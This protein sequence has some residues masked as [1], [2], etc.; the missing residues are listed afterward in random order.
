[1]SS[2]SKHR[3]STRRSKNR[4]ATHAGGSGNPVDRLI[5]TSHGSA[6]AVQ[7]LTCKEDFVRS[8]LSTILRE[9]PPKNVSR[10]IHWFQCQVVRANA[11]SIS[12]S[13]YTEINTYFALADTPFA[14]NIYGLFDQY[15]IY[16][17]VVNVSCSSLSSTNYLGRLTTAI[18][19]DS[20][21]NLGTESA[22][23]QYSTAQMVEVSP[24]LSV[25]RFIKPCV[26]ASVYSNS[27]AYA[28]GR[29]WIDS[30]SDTAQHYGFRS[31]W[32]GNT[33]SNLVVDLIC[34][35][36]IGARCNL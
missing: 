28:T 33:N 22:I 20:V 26:D 29:L 17:V 16:A 12:S 31:F 21:G 14:S 23:Q 2:S 7:R 11:A 18:D 35:Y 9:S 30:Q 24:G 32:Y 13:V 4:G 36:I 10:Q 1:M 3:R 8:Q 6:S 34:T 25:Q 5:A 19:Y 15:C 27:S